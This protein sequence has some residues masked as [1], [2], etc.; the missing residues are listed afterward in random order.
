MAK[1]M[2]EP[3]D[4][5]VGARVR[6]RRLILSMSQEKLGDAIGL[7]F[8]QVQKYEKGTNRISASRLQNISQILQVPVSSFFEDAPTL[9]GTPVEKAAAPSPTYVTNFLASADGLALTKAFMSISTPKLRRHIVHLV[10]ELAD[11][12]HLQNDR[13]HRL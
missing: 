6:M 4:K 7:T 3:T 2:P 9:P 5:H 8:Q 12:D 10:Q 1:G 13:A 11:N